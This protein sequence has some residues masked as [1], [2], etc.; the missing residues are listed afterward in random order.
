MA[1]SQ[2]LYL[3][4]MLIPLLFAGFGVHLSVWTV[5][6]PVFR[7]ACARSLALALAEYASPY[8]GHLECLTSAKMGAQR[9]QD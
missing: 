7:T 6:R 8:V 3:H 2:L 5:G 1:I 9:E 4:D